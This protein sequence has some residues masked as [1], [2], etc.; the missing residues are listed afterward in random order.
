[1]SRSGYPASAKKA[2]G[3][4]AMFVAVVCL[5]T[6]HALEAIQG[7]F[8]HTDH[9]LDILKALA[10][11]DD[12]VVMGMVGLGLLVWHKLVELIEYRHEAENGPQ[13]P[14]ANHE[15]S[16]PKTEHLVLATLAIGLAGIAMATL[17]RRGPD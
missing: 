17:L 1:M 13:T 3:A 5:E 9:I 10:T 14:I 2:A 15:T 7:H 16:G 4:A 8:P 11:L 12:A 6:R